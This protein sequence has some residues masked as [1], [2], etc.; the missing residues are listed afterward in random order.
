MRAASTYRGARRSEIITRDGVTHPLR[1]LNRSF[2]PES[3]DRPFM[4]DPQTAKMQRN[5]AKRE[6]KGRWYSGRVV[7]IE[8]ERIAA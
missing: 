8:P 4:R 7:M 5:D 1:R 2:A 6:R 3:P